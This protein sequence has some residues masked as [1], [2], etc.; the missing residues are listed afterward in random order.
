[1]QP[2]KGIGTN[3]C[4]NPCPSNCT[5][6]GIFLF[7]MEIFKEI[8]NLLPVKFTK[9]L[10]EIELIKTNYLPLE[11]CF[12]FLMYCDLFNLINES[13]KNIFTKRNKRINIDI[14]FDK[15]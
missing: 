11:C 15:I 7:I 6:W 10:V 1:M 9:E 3:L 2:F 8:Y 13:N 4:S 12:P 5:C 14:I